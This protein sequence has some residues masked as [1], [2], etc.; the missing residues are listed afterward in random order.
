MAKL[1]QQLNRPTSFASSSASDLNGFVDNRQQPSIYAASLIH[2]DSE[3][4]TTDPDS[5]RSSHNQSVPLKFGDT[6]SG[7]STSYSR[8]KSAT[9][10]LSSSS[11]VASESKPSEVKSSD[12]LVKSEPFARNFSFDNQEIESL[13]NRRVSL[14]VPGSADSDSHLQETRRASSPFTNGG[15]ELLI[16]PPN[17]EHRL[18]TTAIIEDS[19]RSSKDFNNKDRKGD[20]FVKVGSREIEDT[21][22]KKI[23][24]KDQY[25]RMM[26][27]MAAVDNG[28]H[29][30]LSVDMDNGPHR[31]LPVDV[32]DSFIARNKTPPRYPPPKP[33]QAQ[34]TM[35]G[36]AQKTASIHRDNHISMPPIPISPPK[37]VPTTV[38]NN[39]ISLISKEH[40]E[41]QLNNI[42]KYQDALRKRK[43]EEERLAQ[44]AEFLNRSLRGS[45]KL[46][47]LEST[48]SEKS[49]TPTGIVNDAYAD[50]E[51]LSSHHTEA[52]QVFHEEIHKI[53]NYGE[54][55]ASLQ[56]LQLQLKKAGI[57]GKTLEPV[58][59]L[60]QRHSFHRA[61]SIHNKVQQVW[62]PSKLK[63]PVTSDAKSLITDCLKDLQGSSLPEA[64]KLTEFLARN[65]VEELLEAHDV[66][67]RNFF[68]ETEAD[69]VIQ[70][71][72]IYKSNINQDP[73]V[74]IIRIE[75][76]NEPLGATVRN[77]G[78]TVII[79]RV[80]KGGTAEKCGLLHEGDEILEVNGVEMRGKTVNEVCDILSAMSGVLTFYINPC[81]NTRTNN[82]NTKDVLMYVK[83]L[84]DYDAEDDS[85]VPCKELGI[86][87]QKGDILIV[88]SQEDPNWWQAYR[89]GEHD[90]S[91]AGLIPSKTFQQQ[92]EAL[93]QTIAGERINKEKSRKAGTFLCAKK[94][95][96]K[97][98]KKS[99]YHT[100]Q[101]GGY[102]LYSSSSTDEYDGEEIPTYE[103]VIWYYPSM[104]HKRPIVLIGPPNIGRHELRQ[105]LMEDSDRFAAAVPHTS[106]SRKEG[107]ID[108]QDYHFITRS[109]FEADILARRF[110]EHGEYEKA[111]YGTS[112]EAIRAVVNSGKICVLNL[113]AQSLKILR[114]S[115]LMPYVVFVAPPSLEKLRQKKIK[116]GESYKEEELKDIIEKAREME[117]KYG[118]YFDMIIINN[119]TERAYHELLHEINKVEREPQWIPASWIRGGHVRFVNSHRA[120]R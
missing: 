87:F 67:V 44:E 96:K 62:S 25:D 26:M 32:P 90:H 34:I 80:V 3:K 47:A 119:D 72:S 9:A 50:D 40:T 69:V 88:K 51:S 38:N 84:F 102:P 24:S 33:K 18:K 49:V 76:T 8:P 64:S 43:E 61:L 63:K 92:R 30:E 107:E 19:R 106:R 110:V 82:Y 93:K 94:N 71:E 11:K 77:E 14:C 60:L 36:S 13:K 12:S 31:E 109:Q 28:P 118:H 97:K 73:N 120:F 111:Y 55:F 65:E 20:S 108:G 5:S 114:S 46:Q 68:P 113:H 35:N 21:D 105:R 83:A 89:Y 75:K 42:K 112:L 91:L 16:G 117:D 95:L 22:E 103:E 52:E 54:L 99:P 66:I 45:K 56:R 98:R 116:N 101:D 48:P 39:N 70:D 37:I 29:R 1:C 4:D 23:L 74:K 78:D 115:D 81:Q 10:E 104:N 58:H 85:Y 27:V 53:L 41:E 57:N 6:S 2:T 86:S 17:D 59:S 15:T 79:G 100:Y 7:G